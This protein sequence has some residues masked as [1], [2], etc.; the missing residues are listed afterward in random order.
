MDS[1]HIARRLKIVEKNEMQ[2]NST[3]MSIRPLG[4]L[5]TYIS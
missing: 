4:K 2:M 5:I 3:Q 1:K